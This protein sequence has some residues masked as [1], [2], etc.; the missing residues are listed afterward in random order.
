M[1][2]EAIDLCHGE[3]TDR[4]HQTKLNGM[5]VAA[6]IEKLLLDAANGTLQETSNI[7]QILT[8]YSTCIDIP[9][10]TIQLKM[11]PDLIKAYNEKHPPIATVTNVRSYSL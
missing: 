7:S 1:N 3:L 10:L 6:A 4:F 11:I 2:F 9:R 5:P 8:L